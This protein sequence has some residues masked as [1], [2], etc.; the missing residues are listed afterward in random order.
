MVSTNAPKTTASVTVE[1]ATWITTVTV[2]PI[3]A[4]TGTCSL[5]HPHIPP[6]I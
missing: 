6:D 2:P 4:E 3:I 1:S 5:N